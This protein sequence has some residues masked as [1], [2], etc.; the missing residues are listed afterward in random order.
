MLCR[1]LWRLS[2]RLGSY[3]ADLC[4]GAQLQGDGATLFEGV[5]KALK[6]LGDQYL[7]RG[8][9]LIS[10]RVHL[11][12]RDTS[13]LRKLQ[14]LESIYKKWRTRRRAVAWRC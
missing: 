6:P 8:Y 2:G 3:R 11:E 7:A 5:N 12:E 4:Q 14:P 10:R 13:L 9:R 1:R